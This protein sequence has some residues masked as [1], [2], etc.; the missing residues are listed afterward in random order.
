MDTINIGDTVIEIPHGVLLDLLICARIG[1]EGSD[2]TLGEDRAEAVW[3]MLDRLEGVSREG[4][5]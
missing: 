4:G 5:V 3:S 1:A 2:D